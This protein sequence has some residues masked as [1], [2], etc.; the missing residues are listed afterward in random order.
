[1][2]FLF[3][4]VVLFLIFTMGCTKVCDRN[5]PDLCDKSC[6]VDSDCMQ[7]CPIGCINKNIKYDAPTDLL[8]ERMDCK[9]IENIC[10]AVEPSF[11]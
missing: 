10:T 9:C 7:A 8:C 3:Y 6:R 1:M 2:R 5:Q 4:T 11:E